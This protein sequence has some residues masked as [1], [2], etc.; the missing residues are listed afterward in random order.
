MALLDKY[1]QRMRKVLKYLEIMGNC[2]A[3][4]FAMGVFEFRREVTFDNIHHVLMGSLLLILRL[5]SIED[6]KLSIGST[7]Y[8][9]KMVLQSST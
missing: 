9:E 3:V 1:E 6:Q 2:Y 7:S 5:L 4:Q 8:D